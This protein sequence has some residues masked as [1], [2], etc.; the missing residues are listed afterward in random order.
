[1][2]DDVD[3]SD[4][5]KPAKLPCFVQAEGGLKR[6]ELDWHADFEDLQLR[7]G[8][9]HFVTDEREFKTMMGEAEEYFEKQIFDLRNASIRDA[10]ARKRR[11]DYVPKAA[12]SIPD[13]N[14]KLYNASIASDKAPVAKGKGKSAGDEA[15]KIESLGQRRARL[16]A[17]IEQ[18]LCSECGVVCVVVPTANGEPE[19]KALNSGDIDVW[20]DHA[21][22]G[23]ATTTNPP[24]SLVLSLT[25]KPPRS[26]KLEDPSKPTNPNTT[27]RYSS[28]PPPF[29]AYGY[30]Y[31]GSYPR[32]Y[33][34]APY[35]GPLPPY[36]GF[37]YGM[38][39]FAPPFGTNIPHPG[40]YLPFHP[41]P[42]AAGRH[43]GGPGTPGSP[44]LAD[45]LPPLDIGERGRYGDGFGTLVS[46]FA[47]VQ[48]FR[49]SHLQNYTE[50]EL[51]NIMFYT[52]TG[53]QFH[54]SSP[55][56][57]RLV[58]FVK[59]DLPFLDPPH[60]EHASAPH[61]PRAGLSQM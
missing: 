30:P 27:R 43:L 52:K 40:S 50:E 5:V 15:G 60:P 21:S 59:A 24:P 47:A 48:I 54:L 8:E 4:L 7:R 35:Y 41:P 28:H 42:T 32:F 11:R 58:Q 44:W 49:L 46:G 39:S 9:R 33:G 6:L 25:D 57:A 56:A 36:S 22:R 16:R 38:P 3:E 31:P 23:Q 1:M 26:R 45:W 14:L 13:F 10:R 20:A 34:A 2:E 29:P 53:S 17:A 37:Q 18:N 51:R 19:H 61:S 12:K 55:T